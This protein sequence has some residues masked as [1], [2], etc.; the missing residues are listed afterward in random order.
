MRDNGFIVKYLL[1]LVVQILFWAFFDLSQFL[2][3]CI[4]P[5][6]VLC[7]PIKR[8]TVY[9]MTVA[10]ITGF[11]ADFVTGGILGLTAFALIPVALVRMPVLRLSFGQEL[12]FRG[13]NISVRK[14]GMRKMFVGIIIVTTVFL[15]MYVWAD[16]AGT[17][18]FWFNATKVVLSV[19]L[20]SIVSIMVSVIL[21]PDSH[22]KWI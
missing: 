16:G 3:L 20:S 19:V 15:V 8:S 4:L 18:P 14:L 21:C 11:L 6:M 12:I 13:D 9:S 10:F 17:R 2:M 1:L 5:T 7:I 22:S